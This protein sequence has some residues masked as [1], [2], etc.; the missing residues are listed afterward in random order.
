ML[1]TTLG[2]F[3]LTA[4]MISRHLS[5]SGGAPGAAA[6][7]PRPSRPCPRCN[8][9]VPDRSTY[10]P[11]CGV[12]QQ[13]FEVVQA[14]I[15]TGEAVAGGVPKAAVRADMCVGCG[16]CAA[17]CPVDG[18]I[19]LHGKLAVVDDALCAGHGECV[20]ACPVG[21]I[22]VTTGT[23]VNRVRVPLIDANFESNV[24]G[25]YIVGELGGRGLIKNA[26]NEGKLAV[27]HLVRTLA[28]EPP[29]EDPHVVDVAVVGSGPAGLSAG[30]EALRLGL[31]VV[32]IEQGTLSD[33]VR[34]YPR[35]KLLLAEPVQVPLYGDLWIA[36]A[37][38]ET[39]LQVWETIVANTGLPVR[40]GERVEHVVRV[41]NLLRVDTTVGTQL[42][43]KVVLALGR[44]GT[45]RRLG[46]PGEELDKVFYDIIEM[47]AF[48]GRRVLVV[49]GGDS[50]VESV[51]GLINQADTA[52][53]LS[54]RGTSWDRV[55][56]RNR[57]K[58]E[59]AIADG[60]VSPLLQSTV[61]EV[62]PDVAVLEVDGETMI[63]PNDNVIVRIGGDAPYALLERLGVRIVEKELPSGRA[64]P[65][66]G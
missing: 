33:T 50:A 20:R 17:S 43:R 16:T 21:A 36:D 19:T 61:R 10:C 66:A 64:E 9:A 59:Q 44:R 4:L 51:L 42:A 35:H 28:T 58:L 6:P 52:V 63:L 8:A 60:R 11:G 56:E 29:S 1:W 46:V 48:Q 23:A 26:I 41:G 31:R 39:L 65:K 14:R 54:Y 34:K 18:A 55:K 27:E 45:P 2:F 47:E 32:V 49:G 12:P 30:L 57:L 5:R 25:L 13:V 40:T 22:S 37:S 7:P 38:K 15:A 3:A 53:T 62:R 24:P